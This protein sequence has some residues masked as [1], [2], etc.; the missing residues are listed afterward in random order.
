MLKNIVEKK[1]ILEGKCEIQK[2]MRRKQKENL[3]NI[4]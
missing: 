4:R 3:M 1:N 2:I